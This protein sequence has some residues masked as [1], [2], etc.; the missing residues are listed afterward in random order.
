MKHL[1]TLLL[2]SGCCAAAAQPT[3]EGTLDRA[4]SVDLKNPDPA[5]RLET[6]LVEG[7]AR[8]AARPGPVRVDFYL[9]AL[10]GSPGSRPAGSVRADLPRADLPFADQAHGFSHRF[11][12]DSP[13]FD[14]RVHRLYAVAGPVSGR[15][16]PVALNGS[17]VE[18]RCPAN[19]RQF[20]ARGDGRRDDAPAI[21]AAVRT[22]TQGG[23]N[24]VIYF[25]A[26]TYG[27]G[28]DQGGD[29]GLFCNQANTPCH[30]PIPNAILVGETARQ[31]NGAPPPAISHV[32]FTGETAEGRRLARL[33]LLP[34]T[35]LRML[36][37]SQQASEVTITNLVFDGNGSQRQA[38]AWP[39]GQVVDA[40]IAGT[41]TRGLKVD[42]VEITGGI[43]DG[44]GCWACADF[45][46]Q[47]SRIAGNGT[48]VAGG[49]GIAVSNTRGGRVLDNELA[50]NSTGVWVAFGSSG[51]Q[52]ER[53][54]ITG[55]G[56]SGLAIG[57]TGPNI[58]DV[59]IR[60]NTITGSGA[61]GEP[62][63]GVAIVNASGRNEL[64]CNRIADNSG[65][66]IFIQGLEVAVPASEAPAGSSSG[67]QVM[68][69]TV[70]QAGPGRGGR[71]VRLSGDV[72]GNQIQDNQ[73]DG[74]RSEWCEVQLDRGAGRNAVERNRLACGPEK[75]KAVEVAKEMDSLCR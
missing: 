75:A 53:N 24:A 55:S 60:R 26:G 65:G 36:T 18:I 20:G 22:A 28:T 3:I 9:G 45:T 40:L 71:A 61:D 30:R 52:I 54:R 46:V 13:V 10:P 37:V 70:S 67:W 16:R 68:R 31:A 6:C 50:N 29:T 17:P 57:G 64:S 39:E 32:L 14:G 33:K 49:A 21:Q 42:Q 47:R 59:T 62:W 58:T 19:V 72:A 23:G 1:F 11:A 7:W 51:V 48:R 2:I 66:G 74:G 44:V 38:A 69:N 5:M 12:P 27:L 73:L 4:R 25:P 8:D 56:K 15:A 43:E 35:Q 34:R 41:H 63:A